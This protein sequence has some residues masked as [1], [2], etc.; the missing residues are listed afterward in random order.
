MK[1]NN[2]FNTSGYIAPEYFCDRKSEAKQIMEAISSNRNLTLISIRRMGK[3]A[4]LKHVEN[5]LPKKEFEVIYLDLLPT[6]SSSEFLNLLSSALISAR[7]R[8][9]NIIDKLVKTLSGLRPVIS[10][11]SLTGQPSVTLTV[12]STNEAY[13]GMKMVLEIISGIKKRI[14]IVLDEFQQ[15]NFYEE[16]NIEALL[17][18]IV[19]QFPSISF[20]F[21][22]SNKHML[23]TMFTSTTRPFFG[24]ADIL[25]L[26]EIPAEL[27]GVFI[28]SHFKAGGMHIRQEDINE[29]LQ[30]CRLHTYYV[31]YFCNR[32]YASGI[33]E[34]NTDLL[35][36]I[37]VEILESFTPSFIT[38]QKLLT[39][40]QYD[41]LQAIAVENGV[42]QP[43]SG[44]FIEKYKLKVSSTVKASLDSLA[45]KE[46][47]VYY[48]NT[49]QV[50]DV[51]LM[52][53]L[54]Y[55]YKAKG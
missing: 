9:R 8:E 31:Q 35:N 33:N 16:K 41:L 47:I 39:K 6:Q 29:I 18:S 43:H 50:Y 55:Y 40:P 46:V 32:L 52:R 4:L 23:E 3:T 19:Q 26:E 28:K 25:N 13:D 42:T 38:F 44:D 51:F 34:I 45:N 22:G 54:E 11:D 5:A 37:K 24:S 49:W 48:K 17:R 36:K 15:I 12:S 20:V 14:V 21:S 30:W 1:V 7:N 27:Y 53:W 10:Y 2:P